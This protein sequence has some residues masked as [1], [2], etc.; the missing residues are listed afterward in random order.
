[1]AFGEAAQINGF[2]GGD[3]RMRGVRL[4]I[5]P[6]AEIQGRARFRGRSQAEVS[7]RAKL[8]SPL[9]VEM[10]KRRPSYASPRFY[11]G[12]ALRWCA[13][14]VLGLVVLLLMPK[15]F[16]DV[17]R[18][19]HRYGAALG[20]GAL[21]L[22]ATPV[23]AVIACITL[24]GLPVGIG[25]LLLWGLTLYAAQVFVGSWLGEKLLGESAGTAAML[26]RL[27]LGLAVIRVLGQVP[28][29]GSLVWLL[30]IIWG[31]GALTLTL[32]GRLRAQPA[33]AQEA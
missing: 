2:I 7:P 30:V 1:M 27:A 28:Y 6:T 19:S 24:V 5:G 11:F 15:L 22:V 12:Q 9:E 32:Y 8:A 31:M 21:A 18:S 26:G 3:V 17:L 29:L 14:F 33:A 23:L 10:V 4:S 13:A 16:A 20:V 25:T